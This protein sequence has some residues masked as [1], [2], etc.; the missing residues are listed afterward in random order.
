MTSNGRR[1]RRSRHLAHFGAIKDFSSPSHL[2]HVRQMPQATP[3][4]LRAEVAKIG[5][6]YLQLFPKSQAKEREREN[7]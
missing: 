2:P 3:L 6:P 7:R 4:L 1:A 5:S